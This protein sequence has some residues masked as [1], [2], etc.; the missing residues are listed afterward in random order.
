MILWASLYVA[1]GVALAGWLLFGRPRRP[2]LRLP[3]LRL[4]TLRL[5]T[6][7]RSTPRPARTGASGGV[8]GAG[9]GLAS[10]RPR[11]TLPAAATAPLPP[12]R[13]RPA[14]RAWNTLRSQRGAWAALALLL[15]AAPSALLLH[16]GAG[17]T[18]LH[19]YEEQALDAP[20][21]PIAELLRGE[22]LV[23]PPA[24]PPEVFAT[25]EVEQ[26]RPALA[27]ADR[28]WDRLDADFEQR[29][30]GVLQLMRERHGYDM[31]LIEGVRSP[32]RQARLAALGP[33]V[34]QAA[35]W[36]SWHQY[37]LAADCAFLRDGR[38]V[39]SERDPWAWRGYQLYGQLAESAGLRWGGRW[40]LM[41]LG[42]VELPRAGVRLPLR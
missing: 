36:Q 25:A 12:P 28:R 26:V 8:A 41:D 1:L 6:G 3:T 18:P 13:R 40:K 9:T 32:E 33:A 27:S 31:V 7:R 21:G 20:S 35:A 34:T 37:G 17:Q 5:P 23:P 11:T 16:G 38:L 2:N 4:P 24:L 30:L 10:P 14:A 39:I 22:Q 15:L 42:H 19:A 29:L